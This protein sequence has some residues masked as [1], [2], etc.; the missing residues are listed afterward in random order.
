MLP[1]LRTLLLTKLE[2]VKNGGMDGD[3]AW[4]KQSGWSISGGKAVF[5]NT[6]A[7]QNLQQALPLTPGR[8]YRVAFTVTDFTAGGI[9]P[10]LEGGS[11]VTGTLRTATGVYTEE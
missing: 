10:R 4:T 7:A 6:G 8:R 2:L 5:A 9:T 11:T 1:R 3:F